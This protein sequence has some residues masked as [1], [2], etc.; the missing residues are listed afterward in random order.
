MLT[1][2]Q[3]GCLLID[4]NTDQPVIMLQ[5]VEGQRAIPIVIGLSEAGAIASELER[6]RF[7]RPMTHDLLCSVVD[8]L[9]AR[10]ERVV[11]SDLRDDTFFARIVL[12]CSDRPGQPLDVDARPS[13]AIALAV[14]CNAPIYAE[15]HVLDSAG[16]STGDDA[17][18]AAPAASELNDAVVLPT[19]TDPEALRS[20]LERLAPE[21][22]GKY[23]M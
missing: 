1:E 21:D 10:I 5:D 11:I 2:L 18:D 3:I 19:S 13:D 7:P 6:I 22:F 20:F 15:N 14:R 23:K 9:G 8:S 12:R 16:V 17:P 4:T